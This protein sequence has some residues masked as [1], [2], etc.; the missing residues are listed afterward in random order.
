MSRHAFP[1]D[2]ARAVAERW[3]TPVVGTF[4]RPPLPAPAQLQA[5]LEVAYLAGQETDEGRPLAFTLCCTPR[6]DAVRRHD[7]DEPIE[8]WTL[9]S[10]RAFDVQEVK[11]FAICGADRVWHWAEAKIVGRDQVEVSSDKVAAPVAVRYA[12]ADNPVCNLYSADGLPV[13][14]FR[15]D[16]FEMTTKPKASG[17]TQ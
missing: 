15:T 2:L 17:A 4:R 10:P 3:S 11:G 8:A 9:E 12:W 5:L 6:T 14:P 13:T 1:A 16:D 7:R